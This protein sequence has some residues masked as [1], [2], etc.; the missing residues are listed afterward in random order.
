MGEITISTKEYKELVS[1]SE[2]LEL[3]ERY[4]GHEDSY[5]SHESFVKYFGFS[6]PGDE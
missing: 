5:I 4:M 2:R 3:I 1:K 6:L